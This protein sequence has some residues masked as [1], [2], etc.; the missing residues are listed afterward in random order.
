MNARRPTVWV[1]SRR[2]QGLTL[3]EL[4]IG[5]ALSLLVI[6]AITY[7]F[8]ASRASYRHQESFSAVQESGRIALEVLARDIR[9]AGNPGCG[10]LRV[11]RHLS[12]NAAVPAA[13]FSDRGAIGG[14]QTTLTVLRGSAEATQLVANPA[15]NQI[16]VANLAALGVVQNGDRLLL[17]DCVFTEVITVSNVAGNQVTA[18]NALS[19][20]FPV[21]RTQIM[22]LEQVAFALSPNNELTRN[23][24]PLVGG[25]TNLAFQ[26]GL[27]ANGST[28]RYVDT[29]DADQLL[30]SSAVRV[31]MT[32]RDRDV[33]MP[34]GTTITLRNR[35]P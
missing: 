5:I 6:L 27:A 34:F 19:R 26:Y 9:M 24:Q 17:S 10:D 16:Q 22:R 3:V 8:S 2:Q 30:S 14:N 32:I 4:M 25:V 1:L 7:V 29:P 13:R 11:L 12:E 18:Q 23:G 15:A 35:A 31:V 33:D 20:P 28:T 21:G